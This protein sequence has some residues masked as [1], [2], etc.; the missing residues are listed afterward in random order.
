MEITPG[1]KLLQFLTLFPSMR[2]C[3][4]GICLAGGA[5]C[6]NG[7]G[8]VRCVD[9]YKHLA[10]TIAVELSGFFFCFMDTIL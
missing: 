5:K 10:R 1:C 9:I 7:F 3:R 4:K 2:V 6:H 8:E